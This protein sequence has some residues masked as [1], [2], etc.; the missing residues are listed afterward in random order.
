MFVVTRSSSNNIKP[1]VF[2]VNKCTYITL[3]EVYCNPVIFLLLPTEV[4]LVLKMNRSL[5]KYIGLNRYAIQI[6]IHNFGNS[7]TKITRNPS[8]FLHIVKAHNFHTLYVIDL[9]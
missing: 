6:Q 7:K 1:S 5:Q 3:F 8:Y 2:C 4:G 9:V